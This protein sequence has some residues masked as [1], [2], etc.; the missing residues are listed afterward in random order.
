MI[1][2]NIQ[3]EILFRVSIQSLYFSINANAVV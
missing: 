1:S 2:A 3:A